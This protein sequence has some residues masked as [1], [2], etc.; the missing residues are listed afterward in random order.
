MQTKDSKNVPK[1]AK[2]G[3]AIG[4]GASADDKKCTL[5]ITSVLCRHNAL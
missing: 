2:G 4:A 1:F 3:A 5:K